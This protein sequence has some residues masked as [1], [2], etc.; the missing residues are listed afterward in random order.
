MELTSLPDIHQGRLG[1]PRPRVP[2]SVFRGARSWFL[3]RDGFCRRVRAASVGVAAT[4]LSRFATVA[5]V[6]LD[7][8]A[9]ATLCGSL[10]SRA[11]CAEIGVV[12]GDAVTRCE[13]LVDV[14]AG[15]FGF[16]CRGPREG[17]CNAGILGFAP[18]PGVIR[19]IGVYSERRAESFL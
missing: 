13:F 18:F 9:P 16:R 15:K 14:S 12:E 3:F 17:G 7:L 6:R 11:G 19:G 5:R 1:E 10:R 4:A 8:G 2:G